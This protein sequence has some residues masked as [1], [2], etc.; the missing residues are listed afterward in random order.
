MYILTN[1]SIL[2]F[3]YFTFTFYLY[4]FENLERFVYQKQQLSETIENRYILKTKVDRQKVFSEENF[5]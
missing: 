2:L 1:L 3:S 5:M 4:S